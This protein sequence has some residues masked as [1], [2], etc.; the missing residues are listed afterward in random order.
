MDEF[1]RCRGGWENWGIVMQGERREKLT[2]VGG[3][4]VGHGTRVGGTPG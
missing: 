4:R 3:V 1:V 2:T